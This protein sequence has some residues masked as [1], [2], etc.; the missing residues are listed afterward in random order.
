MEMD[1]M[2]ISVALVLAVARQPTHSAS[3][4]LVRKFAPEAEADWLTSNVP[5]VSGPR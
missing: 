4:L 3:K 2:L 5:L 1:W